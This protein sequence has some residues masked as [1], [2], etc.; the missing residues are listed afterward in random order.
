MQ[1]LLK[2]LFVMLL[3]TW[4]P[5]DFGWLGAGAFFSRLLQD[6]IFQSSLTPENLVS[7]FLLNILFF[8]PLGVIA[9]RTHLLRKKGMF[10]VILSGIGVSI[11][12]EFGQMFLPDRF[13]SVL[14][15]LANGTGNWLGALLVQQ[16]MLP[17]FRLPKA[18]KRPLLPLLFGAIWLLAMTI[19]SLW[20]VLQTHLQVWRSDMPLSIG[21]DL[22]GNWQWNGELSDVQLFATAIPG[23]EICADV[24]REFS[25]NAPKKWI[26]AVRQRNQ[27]S[28]K[29]RIV[30]ADTLQNGP[31]H[32]VSLSENYYR[33]N[34]IIGQHF[35][36]LMVNLNTG[37]SQP[38]GS[39]PVLIA[40]N[41]LQP[42]KPVQIAVTFEGNRLRL[43]VDN[44][45]RAVLVFAPAAVAFANFRYVH[46][47]NAG[48]LQWLFWAI[49]FLPS[50]IAMALFFN[51][52]N[53]Q[54]KLFAKVSFMLIPAAIFWLIL[55]GFSQ[56]SFDWRE[57]AIAT[58]LT[59][60]GWLIAKK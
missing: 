15:V 1:R 29:M 28:L 3:L 36:G 56:F 42:G 23:A 12:I 18:M 22:Q 35:S 21:C 41:V 38:G 45:Q 53:C 32:I 49:I 59:V 9:F 47:Q 57:Y 31:V 43:F 40:E 26:E 5:F 55:C 25:P 33:G 17:D 7:D 6:F 54:K 14:D 16:K 27:F 51:S 11:F 37:A 24:R 52:L 48:Q 13:P 30:P 39:N 10:I 4:F 19:S 20:L 44:E 34:L 8:M 60:M 50:G 58:G 46:S 2:L